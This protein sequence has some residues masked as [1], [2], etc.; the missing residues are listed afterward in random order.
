MGGLPEEQEGDSP[1]RRGGPPIVP[2][3]T[4]RGYPGVIARSLFSLNSNGTLSIGCVIVPWM[5]AS[6]RW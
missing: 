4:R 2:C 3:P 1:T 6:I 5:K